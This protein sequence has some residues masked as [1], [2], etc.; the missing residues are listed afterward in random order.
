MNKFDVILD[1]YETAN[2]L[3]VVDKASHAVLLLTESNI[4]F[5]YVLQ[6][7]VL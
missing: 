3:Q 5:I 7:L 2:S 6:M 4:N 1:E